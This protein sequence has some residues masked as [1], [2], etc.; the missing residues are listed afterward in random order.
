MKIPRFH[1]FPQ[2]GFIAGKYAEFFIDYERAREII[3]E[4]FTVGGIEAKV[5]YP[6]S[7]FCLLQ[8][9]F[10][11]D[12]FSGIEEWPVLTLKGTSYKNIEDD[13]YGVLY[14][15][16]ILFPSA[17]G[18]LPRIVAWANEDIDYVDIDTSLSISQRDF[19]KPTSPI[20]LRF[21]YH[22]EKQSVHDAILYYYKVLEYFFDSAWNK[23]IIDLATQSKGNVTKLTE[24]LAQGQPRDEKKYLRLVVH[25][26]QTDALWKSVRAH[27]FCPTN[28]MALAE[29]LYEIRNEI[30]HS[31]ASSKL[32]IVVPT[33]IINDELSDK[34]NFFRL[35]AK[36]ALIKFG[37]IVL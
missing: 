7:L 25:Y 37:G 9:K 8:K 24:L 12:Y 30:V 3:D 4:Q 10:E 18:D 29:K 32:G 17:Y 34:H 20:A 31:K 6:S 23:N 22:A 2:M 13:I 16:N 35:L 5:S 11:D 21:F 1:L 26:V 33:M 27:N 19:P 28:V 14:Y 15:L 36:E